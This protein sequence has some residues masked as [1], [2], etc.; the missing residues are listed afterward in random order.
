[1]T[2]KKGESGNPSGRPKGIKDKRILRQLLDPHA[3]DLVNKAVELAL[4]GDTS[5]LRTCLERLVPAYKAE[6]ATVTVP[7]LTTAENITEQGQI[8][9]K[10][11]AS[12]DIAVD[13]ALA[14]LNA[15][16]QQARLEEFGELK[17]RLEAI[18]LA[19]K[20]N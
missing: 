15:I 10:A 19:L 13:D 17:E 3:E 8:I 11:I 4:N 9:L 6:S 2:F 18:E 5:M 12:G 16:N 1:M 7:A 20:I 14:V